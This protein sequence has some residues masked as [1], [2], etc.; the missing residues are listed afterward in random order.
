MVEARKCCKAAEMIDQSGEEVLEDIFA[1]KKNGTLQ[2]RLSAMMMY[3]RWARSTGLMAFPLIETQCY[4]YVDGLRRDGAP[5]TRATSFRG[6]LAFCKGTIQLEGVDEVLESTRIAGSSHR[7]YMTKRVLKQR[8]ALTVNQVMTLEAVLAGREFPTQDRLFAGHCLLCVYGRLRMGDSQGIENEPQVFGG[9]LE[10]GTA[11]HKT[12]G[13]GGRARRVLPVVAPA[14][15]VSGLAWAEEFLKLRHLAGLKALPGMPFLPT[16]VVGGGWSRAKLATPEATVWL[17][18]VLQKYSGTSSLGNVGA[19]SLKATALS[20]MMV[21]EKVRRLM[22]YHVKPKDKSVMIYSRDALAEG[23]E[24]LTG[25]IERI[26][27][28]KF[29]PDAPRN[30]RWQHE[31]EPGASTSSP[32]VVRTRRGMRRS[33]AVSRS[34]T[35]SRCPLQTRRCT[36]L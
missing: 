12:D 27:N 21:H 4:D 19:H 7:S 30:Q 11:I 3:V 16:P 14:V 24:T 31:D 35:C 10:G 6:A 9:Y 22:G 26:R 1:R 20:W 28:L 5:A 8:D 34:W 29:R 23:L 33:L 18:E 32:G 25:I 2:V 15:G 17:C 13:P 36:A